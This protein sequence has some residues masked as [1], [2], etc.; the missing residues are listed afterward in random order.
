[1][2]H[3]KSLAADA[4]LF[5]FEGTLVDFQWQ[6][7]A[8][9][10]E[11]LDML[12]QMGFS[13][14]RIVSRKYSTLLTEAMQAAPEIG[15]SPEQVRERIGAI[16]DRYDADALTRWALRPHVLESLAA[17]KAKGIRTA[18]VSNLGG[19]TLAAALSK[20]CLADY[21]DVV[22][23]RY[24]VKNLKPSPEGLHRALIKLGVSPD[25][26]V[27][28]GDSLDDVN[29]AKNAGI[30]VMII[31]AGE[32]ATDEILAAQPDHVIQCYKEL[33]LLI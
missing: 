33:L 28:V 25:A 15:L 20:F 13:P 23:S 4:I 7:S 5:D 6:L 1:M 12:W 31:T 17:I 3:E 2:T 16:Y 27:F 11:T 30:R 9:I 8:A 14:E 29:A 10:E 24:D 21:F 26:G 19:K 18:L 22:L 32:N